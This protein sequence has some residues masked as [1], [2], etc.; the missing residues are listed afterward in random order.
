MFGYELTPDWS[1][2]A[3]YSREHETGFRPIGL[4]FNT[5]PSASLTGGYGAELPEPI[6]YFI[7]NVRV[8]A[9]HARKRWGVQFGYTGSFFE[10][11]IS[12]LVFDNPFRTTDCVAPTDC[13]NATQ[14]PATGGQISIPT[15]MRT[16]STSLVRLLCNK[17]LRLLASINAGWLRQNDPFVPYTTNTILVA[18][19]GPLPATSLH[20]EKANPGDELQAD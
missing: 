10:N 6:D 4:I 1:L 14:G 3:S 11:N 12:A 18:D 9:E 20:G 5:S 17:A 13:T 15:T 8:T 2:L 16:T 19:T 7:N